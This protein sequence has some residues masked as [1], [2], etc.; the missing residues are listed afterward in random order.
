MFSERQ[1]SPIE[2]IKNFDVYSVEANDTVTICHLAGGIE[3]G[4]KEIRGVW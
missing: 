2:R 1:I 4:V 3:V